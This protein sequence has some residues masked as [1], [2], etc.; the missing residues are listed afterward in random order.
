MAV[1]A[2]GAVLRCCLVCSSTSLFTSSSWER[3]AATPLH[4]EAREGVGRR[5]GVVMVG[6]RAGV[7]KR[8]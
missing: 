8:H 1:E 5:G 6:T 3:H 4:R 2:V 7:N